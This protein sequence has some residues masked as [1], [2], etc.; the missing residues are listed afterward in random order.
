NWDY[1][2]S[3]VRD[4]TFALW[5]LYSLGF[6]WE[7]NDFF[8]FITDIAERDAGLQVVYGVDGE[9]TLPEAELGHLDGYEGAKPV[10]VGNAAHDQA[11]HDVWGAVLGSVYVH[12]RSRGRLDERL[13]P[14]LSRQVEAAL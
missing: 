4:S 10:R 2:F 13:W 12:T 8:W 6:D 14:I 3:W 11:Q 5:A 7:A 9:P 1:R